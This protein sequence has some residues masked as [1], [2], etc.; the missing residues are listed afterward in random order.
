M[1]A[2]KIL[3][4]MLTVSFFL[5]CSQWSN[6][7]DLEKTLSDLT[8]RFPQLPKSKSNL[9]DFYKPVKTIIIGNNDFQLQLRSTPRTFDDRQQIII[10]TNSKGQHYAIPFFSNRYR[11]YWNFQFDSPDLRVKPTNTTFEKELMKALDTLNINDTIGTGGS[12]IHIMLSSLLNCLRITEID[13]IYIMGE[14]EN[15]TNDQNLMEET[16]SFCFERRKKNFKAIFDKFNPGESFFKD[17]YWDEYNNRIYQFDSKFDYKK[18]LKLSFKVYR[19][20]C[21]RHPVYM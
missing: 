12:V 15:Y 18:I 1:R 9:T 13:S 19:Q 2:K 4:L 5:G 7:S 10:I 16:D 14:L 8:D 3:I 17:V 21:V 11:D 6:R 20:D